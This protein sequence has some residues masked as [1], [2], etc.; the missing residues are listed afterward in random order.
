MR[1]WTIQ[2][3]EV[4]DILKNNGEFICDITKSSLF[5]EYFKRSYDWLI[6]KMDEK[7]INHPIGVDY[8]IWAWHTMDWKHEKPNLLEDY[9]G[10]KGEE[11]ICLELEVP[12]EDVLLSDFNLWHF[13]LNDSWIDD[14]KNEMEYDL[15][16]E[17]YDKLSPLEREQLKK[18]SWN[19]I[20]DITPITYGDWV[21]IG[22]YVQA[23]F[24]KLKLEYVI[25]METFICH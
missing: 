16:H 8:P 21:S 20:F 13:V 3:K 15:M 1:L 25:N 23:C 22:R 10:E 9:Y 4:Y 2:P 17:Q 14:S 5:D 18:D 11:L 19:K 6:T 7:N 12:D 24:W